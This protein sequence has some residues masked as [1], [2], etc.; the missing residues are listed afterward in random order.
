M[1]MADLRARFLPRFAASARERM[2]RARLHLTAGDAAA[3][4]RELHACAGEAAMLEL[5]D[6]LTLLIAAEDTAKEWVASG[7][8]AAMQECDRRVGEVEAAL[9]RLVVEVA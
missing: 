4:A 5:H 2:Q 8:P 9:Q 3:L 7:T 6:L 1:S